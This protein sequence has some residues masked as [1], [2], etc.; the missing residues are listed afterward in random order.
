MSILS[1]P[2][3]AKNSFKNPSKV[4]YQTHPSQSRNIYK[5]NEIAK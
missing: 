2:R 3:K 1:F 5:S 4:S